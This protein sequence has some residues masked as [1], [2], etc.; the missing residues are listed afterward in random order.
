MPLSKISIDSLDAFRCSGAASEDAAAEE[1]AVDEDAAADEEAAA[2]D[3]AAGV[4]GLQPANAEDAIIA[5]NTRAIILRLVLFFINYLL[6]FSFL[7]VLLKAVL[8]I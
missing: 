1:A 7:S 8:I 2:E 5:L 6:I 3:D 4:A